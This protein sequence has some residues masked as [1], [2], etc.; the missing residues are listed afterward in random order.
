MTPRVIYATILNQYQGVDFMAIDKNNEDD[1]YAGYSIKELFIEYRIGNIEA[2]DEI[3]KRHKHY[4]Y[5]IVKEYKGL[6]VDEEDLL[7]SGYEGLL[8][9]IENFNEDTKSIFHVVAKRYI[10][11]TILEALMNH[12]GMNSFETKRSP[13]YDMIKLYKTLKDLEI[14][15]A[16]EYGRPILLEELEI[17]LEELGITLNQLREVILNFGLIES[18]DSRLHEFYKHALVIPLTRPTEQELIT[19]E[20]QREI[21]DLFQDVPLTDRMRSLL[22]DNYLSGHEPNDRRLAHKYKVT[23]VRIGQIEFDTFKMIRRYK[24]RILKEYLQELSEYE[25]SKS[26]IYSLKQK[27]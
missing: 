2:R 20:I 6:G 14:K 9:A 5:D 8:K 1:K 11:K 19:Q 25:D 3:L 12:F 15:L 13:I 18:V 7:Q 4:V 17:E 10:N 24:R 23:P 22:K 26:P 27:D 21:R 16:Q